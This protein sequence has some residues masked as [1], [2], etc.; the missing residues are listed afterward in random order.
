LECFAVVIK[1]VY[2]SI[3]PEPSCSYSNMIVLFCYISLM[4]TGL[5]LPVMIICL[6]F[7]L[8]VDVV[9]LFE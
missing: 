3:K 2:V 7:I 6:E 8:K 5:L 1:Q 4:K 9:S